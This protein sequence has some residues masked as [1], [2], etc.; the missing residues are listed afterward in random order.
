MHDISANNEATN[1]PART[2][3]RRFVLAAPW[4]W[5][6]TL[7]LGYRVL[8]SFWA[9]WVS[10]VYPYNPIEKALPVWPI[11]ASFGVWLERV[12]L[13]PAARYDV[14]WNIGIAE[15]GY[16]YRTGSTAFHPLYPLLIG[17]LGRAFGGNFLLAGWLIAQVCCVALLALLY[18]LVLL[19]YNEGMARRTT[20]FLI[21]S[22]LGF[23]LLVPY[24][25]S[26][27]LLCIVGALYAAR[28]RRWWLAGLLGASAA[29]T[30]QPGVVVLLPLLWEVW[31]VHRDDLRTRQFRPLLV[32]LLALMF[33]P[34]GLLTYLI[35]RATLGDAEFTWTNPSTLIWALLVTPSY[36][37]VWDHH[38]SFPWVG[39]RVAIDRLRTAPFFYLILNMFLMSIMAVIVCYSALRQRGS[40]VVYSLCL[41]I[42]N[43]SIVY[44]LIPYISVVRRF[45]I[46][47]PLFIQLALWGRSPRLCALILFCNTV[48]WVYIS[49][50]YVRYAYLP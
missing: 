1:T 12:L 5:A 2:R 17:V 44:P 34:L 46:I 31:H 39:L 30:K 28:L 11:S 25:E 36:D 16:A 41:L 48:L 6:L 40:Y 20:L 32:P 47:F 8:W 43:L 23:V 24:A 3:F 49:E 38:F 35:Y 50:A 19:D 42:M 33:V 22:P 26:L 13:W 21:G 15:Q 14:F 27:L 29:L 18:K 7:F 45:L 37:R 9:A 4:R 10:S